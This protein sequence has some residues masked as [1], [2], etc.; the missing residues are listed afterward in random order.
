MLD[1]NIFRCEFSR[2]V[3]LYLQ[4]KLWGIECDLDL[5][6]NQIRVL[7]NIIQLLENQLTCKINTKIYNMIRVYSNRLDVESLLP[8]CANC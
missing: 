7:N 1:I 8:F 3:A 6:Y 4:K 5:L 2:L